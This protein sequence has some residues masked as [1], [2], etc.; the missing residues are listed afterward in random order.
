MVYCPLLS[1][2]DVSDTFD[3]RVSDVQLLAHET[4]VLI[5]L[6]PFP[7]H[8]SDAVVRIT[9]SLGRGPKETRRWKTH[10]EGSLNR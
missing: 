4:I 5:P 7:L 8:C 10:E 6:A 3:V 2:H 9:F 1:G